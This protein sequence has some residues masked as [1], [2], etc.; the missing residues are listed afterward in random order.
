MFWRTAEDR[1]C[2]ANLDSGIQNAMN[3]WKKIEQAKGMHP[4]LDMV[5]HYSHAQDLMH[6]TWR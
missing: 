4:Q 2:A 5:E 1:T 6:V 3:C